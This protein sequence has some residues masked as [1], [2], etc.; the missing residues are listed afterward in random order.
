MKTFKQV[1]IES[2]LAFYPNRSR[3]FLPANEHP[4]DHAYEHKDY[5]GYRDEIGSGGEATAFEKPKGEGHDIA[6]MTKTFRDSLKLDGKAMFMRMAA[7]HAP[8]N[9]HLPRVTEIHSYENKH[10]GKIPHTVYKVERLHNIDDLSH[11][12]RRAMWRHAF[13]YEPDHD[14]DSDEFARAID[15]HLRNSKYAKH[16]PTNPH[17]TD[18]INKIQRVK[19]RAEKHDV[20]PAVDMHSGNIMARRT[21]HGPQLVITDPLVS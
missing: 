15:R 1:L 8:E 6:L 7:R 19:E 18:A 5:E 13:Q 9:P 4:E 12:E 20:Y 10:Q 14:V 16:F 21:P 11:D 2:S 17:L 3:K